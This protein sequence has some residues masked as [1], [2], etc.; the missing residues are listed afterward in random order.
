MYLDESNVSEG[1]VL[2]PGEYVVIEADDT[3]RG[4]DE[5]TKSRIFEPF[6]T[7]KDSGRGTGLGLATTFGIVSQSK[8]HITVS[9]EIGK[10]STFRVYLPRTSSAAEP[11]RRDVPVAETL[12]GGTET[13]LLVEDEKTVRSILN[14]VLRDSGYN[15][16]T[17]EDC[18]EALRVC[19]GYSEPVHIVVTDVAMPEMSGP[20]LV[21][22]LT[23]THS[24]MKVLYISGYTR[25]AIFQSGEIGRSFGYLGKPF[26][27]GTFLR[28]VREVLDTR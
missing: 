11:V 25:E 14:I 4:M 3:G 2:G 18:S 28:K 20:D 17:A 24:E 10:G 5:T 21:T 22:R 13:V 15:V 7:T 9:S 6:F 27:P 16:I 12:Q 1:G 19:A 8:G 23:K 26:T